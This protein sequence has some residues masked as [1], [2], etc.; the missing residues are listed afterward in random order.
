MLT[1][2]LATIEEIG[3]ELGNRL[4]AQRLAQNLTQAELAGRAGVS[5]GTVRNLEGK[6]QASVE[7][8]LR[9][10]GALG[11]AGNLSELFVLR[12]TSIRAMEAATRSRKRASRTEP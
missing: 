5:R 9:I 6:G 1:F 4:R 3:A 10:V 12:S 2:E 11:L 7:S 8:L